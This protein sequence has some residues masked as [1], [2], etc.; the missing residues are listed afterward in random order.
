MSLLW[1][2]TACQPTLIAEFQDRPVVESYLYAGAPVSVTVSKLIPFRDDVTFSNEDV[3]QLSIDLYDETTGASCTLTPQGSGGVYTDSVFLPEAGHA[4]RLQFLY[5]GV[6]VT[7]AT[8]IAAPPENVVFSRTLIGAGMGGDMGGGMP[9]PLEITWDNPNGDYYI[10]TA[11]CEVDNPTPIFEI[12]EDETPTFPLSFQ[13]EVTQGT[14]MQLSSQSFSY[15]GRHLVK[16][17][18]IQ[19]EYVLLYQRMNN[20]TDALAELIANVENGFGIF[21][22]VS[23][24]ETTV[25]VVEN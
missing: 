2:L 11:A 9:T 17:C 8:Q 20:R 15:Y 5:N 13:S 14:S 3:N 23:S 25:Y 24:V 19:P 7:A 4:Y 16:V 21:T 22:G 10:V 12:D 6:A 1:A 18:R